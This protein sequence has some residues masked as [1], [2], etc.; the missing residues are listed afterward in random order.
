MSACGVRAGIGRAYHDPRIIPVA[1]SD[2]FL[3]LFQ[4]LGKSGL[5]FMLLKRE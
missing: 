1:T 3:H 2:P 5:H 4:I